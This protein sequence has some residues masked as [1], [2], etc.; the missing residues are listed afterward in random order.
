[1]PASRRLAILAVTA[2]CLSPLPASALDDYVRA[3]SLQPTE[4]ELC[5]KEGA[6]VSSGA[7]KKTDYDALNKRTEKSLQAALSKA[8][9]NIRPLLKRDQDWFNEMILNIAEVMPR[10]DDD[11]ARDTVVELLR[12]RAAMLDGVAQG[13]G[14]SGV[15]GRWVNAFGS[16][17]VTP[18]DAGY[19]LAIDSRA[20][21]GLD[22][23][24][25]R[26][27]RVA[28]EVKSPAGA[29]FTGAVSP[30]EAKAADD[31]SEAAKHVSIKIRRQ[32]ETL[33]VVLGDE[34]FIYGDRTECNYL[35]QI[36]G[37]YFA[38][39]KADAKIAADKTDTAFVSPTLD[40]ARP[41]SATDEEICADPDLAD[42]DQK[43]N[44]AWKAL[45]PRLDEATRRTLT[46]DQRNWVKAQTWQYPLFLHPAWEKMTYFMHFTANARDKVDR[47]Q[48][49]RIALLDGFDDKRTGLVGVWLAYNAILK[50]TAT[51]DGGIKA[52]G[53]KWEQGDWKAGCDFD[54]AGKLVGGKFISD[55]KRKNP[56]TLE[57]D[58]ASLVVN[59]LDDV[60]AKKRD[61]SD[62]NDE[63]K[64]KRNYSN[65]STARLFPAK[66]SP[67]IN[68]FG[69]SIR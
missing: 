51:E 3:Y 5:G 30:A 12:R 43:L 42:N 60:F 24:R 1:M 62:S 54:M 13:F 20:V 63:P 6:L 35:W 16:I 37:S 7:C 36:T 22:S 64:C 31:K 61:G 57:R 21:Y 65:S 26:E 52:E 49:E 46:D 55:E 39:G 66:P 69:G 10:S 19:R 28:A 50:V 58:R 34:E 38:D 53:W 15:A 41:E 29:W 48:K 47:L 25:R 33:R 18:A 27:C 23:D 9:A 8:P 11:G 17:T 4:L 40:C 68:D 56:D 32:G 59:R 2:A 45:L 14:R 44:R 67:D